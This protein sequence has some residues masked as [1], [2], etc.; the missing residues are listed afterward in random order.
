MTNPVL[1]RLN[2]YGLRP[3]KELGQHFLIDLRVL[4][5]I[6]QAIDPG[7]ADVVLEYGAGVGV[8]TGHLLDAGA[9][10]VAVELD[11]ALADVLRHE[12]G[13][14]PGFRL[15]HADLAR[16]SAPALRAE[17]GVAQ[18]KLAGN[19]P[20]Q[21]TSH[22][23][24]GVLDLEAH[25]HSA[26]FMV[27]REVAERI[28]AAPGTREYGILSVLLR[29]YHEVKI[30]V[31]AKPGAFA[32]PPRVDSA[33]LRI[34][35]RAGGPALGWNERGVFAGL[36]KRTFNE[37]RKVLRNTLKKFYGLDATAL[38]AAE[39]RSGLDF[40]RRPETLSVDEFVR[41]LHVLPAAVRDPHGTAPGS[42]GVNASDED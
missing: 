15:V 10:V 37:R 31:R 20:Y 6:Q 35:P 32:P 38:E 28:V 1:E 29:A 7:P 34:T 21:L 33:V 11:D 36:L 39:T 30:I 13:E 19:L 5:R 23:L 9:R 4:E 8:L 3:R 16:V 18:L 17:L 2:H 14:R 40:G 12:L 22:V 27:Q 41:L 25:L 42:T 24:F 26:V